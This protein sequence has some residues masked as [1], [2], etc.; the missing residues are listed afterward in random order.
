MTCASASSASGTSPCRSPSATTTSASRAWPGSPRCRRR[1]P[2][3]PLVPLRDL[4]HRRA[5][6]VRGGP[7]STAAGTPGGHRA[8][9]VACASP[10]ST[11]TSPRPS[12]WPPGCP[13]YRVQAV[14]G[15]A[16][17]YPPE[18]ADVAVIAAARRGRGV[19]RTAS[20]R[21]T[22]CSR[23]PPGSSPTRTA[24]RRRTWRPCSSRCARRRRRRRHAAAALPP[25]ADRR[26][27]PAPGQRHDALT[28]RAPGHP[29]RP[30]AAPRLRRAGEGRPR[31]RRLRR[32]GVRAPPGEPAS[33]GLEVKVIRPQDMPQ[34]V[35]SGEFDIAI[36]GRDCL[37]EHL[38]RFPSS[39]VEEVAR[40]PARPVQPLRRRRAGPARRQHR[41][42]A[43]AYWRAQGRRAL[44]GRLGVP[45][46][47]DHYARSRHFW[48]YQVMPIAGASE[49]LRA[50]G[51]RAA[52]RRHGDRPHDRREQPQDLS[53]CST[54]RR[55]A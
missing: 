17:A 22:A 55:P 16:E 50:R 43:M 32:E 35:A 15:A 14:G 25:P 34:L 33:T 53:T 39:P 6:A 27:P 37:N 18:D 44:I 40:P 11:R 8:A 38:Y 9:A 21:C 13:R 46:T 7:P 3:Q 19:A 54:A 45:G 28:M 10:A 48:R 52:D 20:S 30:P 29:R 2:Q 41:P 36:T 26:P 42:S 31:L 5:R 49:G 12:P 1:F 51:R 23:T 47:A 4:R 24:S